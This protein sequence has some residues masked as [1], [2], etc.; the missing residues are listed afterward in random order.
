MKLFIYHYNWYAFYGT[1][2]GAP[3][4]PRHEELLVVANN[5]EEADKLIIEGYKEK[6]RKIRDKIKEDNEF[7][8]PLVSTITRWLEN[9][10]LKE[11]VIVTEHEL[12]LGL[13]VPIFNLMRED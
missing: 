2:Y 11:S 6:I 5:R 4:G 12:N 7:D 9:K 8:L 3:N 1:E 10:E 13:I